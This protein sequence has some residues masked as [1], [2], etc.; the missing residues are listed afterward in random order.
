[1]DNDKNAQLTSPTDFTAQKIPVNGT[2]S[3]LF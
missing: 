3:G 1:M 2:G